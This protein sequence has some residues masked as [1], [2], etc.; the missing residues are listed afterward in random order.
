MQPMRRL[1]PLNNKT[2][3]RRARADDAGKLSEIA[4]RTVRETFA[5]SCSVEDM[6]LHCAAEYSAEIQHQ[7]ILDPALVTLVCEQAGQLMG[8]TQVRWCPAPDGCSAANAMEIQR[9]YVERHW[10]GQGVAQQLMDAAIQLAQQQ[11][12]RQIWLGVWEHNLRALAFYAKY[13]FAEA[14]EHTFM[15]GNDLQR[16]LIVLRQA[17]PGSVE[18]SSGL[19]TNV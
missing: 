15:V 7:E 14:G 3:P 12:P 1:H 8:F 13:G 4:E 2:E 11:G 9:L 18:A 10:H 17:Q 5:H 6:H 19:V 16:D